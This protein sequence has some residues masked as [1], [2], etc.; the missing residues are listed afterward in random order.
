MELLFILLNNEYHN[1]GSRSSGIY[2]ELVLLKRAYHDNVLHLKIDDLQLGTFILFFY[3]RDYLPFRS[4]VDDVRAV[5]DGNGAALSAFAAVSVAAADAR[6][7]G[8]FGRRVSF[9]GTA[10]R[11]IQ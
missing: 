8:S 2:R 11:I 1:S 6:A 3:H 7:V 5:F 10:I 9:D 4:V